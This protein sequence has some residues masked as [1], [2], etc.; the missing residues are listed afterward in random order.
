MTSFT[1]NEIK[2]SFIAL[3]NEKEFDK[4][5]IKEISKKCGIN[6]NTFYYH[7]EDIYALL[8]DVLMTE[9]NNVI[10]DCNNESVNQRF[11]ESI[12]FASK[13]KVAL[14]HIF[15]SSNKEEFNNY[16]IKVVDVLL[17]HYIKQ[18]NLL[19]TVSDA[20]EDI[21]IKFYIGAISYLITDWFKNGMKNEPTYV[22]DK[23]V[24]LIGKSLKESLIENSQNIH[25]AQNLDIAN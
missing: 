14:Y 12:E 18:N 11:I 16:L 4:I 7:Y 9:V 8:D 21:I 6:R 3:L 17:K 23:L 15:N 19:V 10:N 20:E 1:K 2:K 22:I 13:N 5:T 25:S 24:D